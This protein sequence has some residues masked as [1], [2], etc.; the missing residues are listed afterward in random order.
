MDKRQRI[1]HFGQIRWM[2]NVVM[3]FNPMKIFFS[4]S[5]FFLAI[6]LTWAI[7]IIM[8]GRGLSVGAMLGIVTGIFFFGLVAEQLS[9][10]RKGKH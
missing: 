6:S 8:M 9:L 1:H 3:L 5:V 7:Q 4:L 10:I 2:L